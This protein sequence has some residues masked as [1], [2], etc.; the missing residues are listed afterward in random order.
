M[1]KGGIS[2]IFSSKPGKDLV[3]REPVVAAQAEAL[4]MVSLP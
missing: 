3:D 2:I 4:G 1:I